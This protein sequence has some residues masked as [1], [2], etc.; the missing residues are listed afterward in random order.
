MKAITLNDVTNVVNSLYYNCTH[1]GD[2]KPVQTIADKCKT[3]SVVVI[4]VKKILVSMGIL[5]L[6]GEKRSQKCYWHASKAKPNAAMILEVYRV[7]TKDFKSKTHIQVTTN[8]RVPSLETCIKTLVSNGFTG[9][10]EKTTYKGAHST[11]HIIDLSK[12]LL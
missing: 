11:K 3:S 1:P 4:K 9:I 7:Y 5:F 10:I 12:I 2:V 6:N 8:K